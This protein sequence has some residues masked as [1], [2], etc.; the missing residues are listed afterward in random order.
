ML[1][2]LLGSALKE[3]ILLYLQE[4]TEGYALEMAKTFSVPV[5]MVQFHLK[6]L[7]EGG[8]AVSRQMGK[9]RMFSLNPRYLF[10]KEVSSLLKAV[11]ENL[12]EEELEKY[13]RPRRRPRRAGKPL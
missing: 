8:I 11:L 10:L 7:E 4:C 6:G 12:P 2:P 3:K 9:T 1:E 5:S 13:Y